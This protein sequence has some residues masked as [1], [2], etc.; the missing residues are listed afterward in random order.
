MV[1]AGHLIVKKKL[2]QTYNKKGRMLGDKK[3][4]MPYLMNRI[5]Q[6]RP[7]MSSVF[8]NVPK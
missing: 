7:D 6:K 5:I 2:T 3:E 1:G 4:W 8:H